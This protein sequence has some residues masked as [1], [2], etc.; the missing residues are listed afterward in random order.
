M[1]KPKN[2]TLLIALYRPLAVRMILKSG[3]FE[4][5]KQ[6]TWLKIV[7]LTP[8]AD[9]PDIREAL[10]GDNVI[11]ECLDRSSL[12]DA[13]RSGRLRLLM[14]TVRHF[15]YRNTGRTMVSRSAQMR[16]YR[17]KNITS[18]LSILGRLYQETILRLPALL[19][20]ARWLR[21]VWVALERWRYAR[22]THGHIFR[23]YRPD[24]LLVS[25]LGY[26][27]DEQLM[28]EAQDARTRVLSIV[29][30][31]DNPTTKG[32]PG[33][34]PD[35]AIVWSHIMQRELEALLDVP[36]EHIFV[37]G[38]PHW[39]GYFSGTQN[40]GEEEQFFTELGLTPGRKVIFFPTSSAKMY[41]DNPLIVR[42]VAEAI[43]NGRIGVP[44]QILVRPHPSYFEGSKAAWR[45]VIASDMAEF[46]TVAR[47]YPGLV[48][49]DKVWVAQFSD[50]Y[51][52]DQS[53]QERLARKLRY[54]TVMLNSYSTQAIEAAALD[55]PIVN[56]A[57]GMYKRTD[58]PNSVLDG[59]EHYGRVIATGGVFN[60]YSIDEMI[61]GLNRYLENP[62]AEADGRRRIVEQEI[63]VNRGCAGNVIGKYIADL[64]L[65]V[66]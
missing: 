36:R 30:S 51:D 9:D 22:K 46:E 56:T 16:E 12:A 60:A 66:R 15:T 21:R 45:G 32:Y 53:E 35:R 10:S 57:F 64:L 55:L 61:V 24:W 11:L 13:Q 62:V 3:V 40:A 8:Y 41:K 4:V 34:V 44:A 49:L 6:Q 37:G 27:Y 14:R 33:A 43:A 65:S 38:V 42:S 26:A 18:Q 47:Q 17:L 1:N 63:P 20:T 2:K 28:W 23:L 7:I 58:L 5:L 31:W 54:S 52:I 59:S 48:H 19:G 29:Q 39:D 25:S 50:Y